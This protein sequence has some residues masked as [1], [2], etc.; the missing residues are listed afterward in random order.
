MNKTK[1]LVV[2]ITEDQEKKLQE[3]ARQKGFLKKSDYVRV[4][5]FMGD[6][7]E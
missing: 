7:N 3:K 1:L 4:A 2:R 6:K 5:L